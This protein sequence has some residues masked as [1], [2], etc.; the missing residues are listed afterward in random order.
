M[1]QEYISVSTGSQYFYTGSNTPS[2]G[3][4]KLLTFKS[5]QHL[6][7]SAFNTGS[8]TVE[9]TSSFDN[10]IESS[11][12]SASRKMV[13]TGEVV[14]FSIPRKY[15][16]THIEPSSLIISSS[17]AS[18]TFPNG[19]IVIDDGEGNLVTGSAHVGNV[20]YSHGQI[21]IT[22]TPYTTYFTENQNPGITFKANT[23]IKTNTYNI[24]IS[25][26]ELN[27][28]LNPTAQSGSTILEYSGSRYVQPSGIYADNVTGSAFHPYITTVGLYNDS[29]QLI[30]VGKLAQPLP[31]PADTELTI[32][33]KLD[34]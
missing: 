21:I 29:D 16:G 9:A 11:F 20:I 1:A 24:K 25:D 27:H 10:Y 12:T 31:K 13:D 8:G 19:L 32:Q 3:I 17:Q 15:Y 5:L 2:G 22:S 30:A 4:N 34:V 23:D 6:Y 33:I 26:Y 18:G 28:T 7:Y 14:L